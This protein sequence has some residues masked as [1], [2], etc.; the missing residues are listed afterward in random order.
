MNGPTRIEELLAARAL[1]GL[2]EAE[3]QELERLGAAGDDSYD[4]AAAAV[5]LAELNANPLPHELAA[6]VL[7][8]AP[9]P[10]AT[11]PQARPLFR[12]WVVGGWA[13]AAA[14]LAIAAAAWLR[15]P[16]TQVV[17]RVIEV[18]QRPAPP[19]RGP[20]PAEARAALLTEADDVVRLP[21]KPTADADALGASGDVVWSESR[22]VGYMRIRGL[23]SNDPSLAQYQLWIFD[24]KRD[25]RHPVDGGVFDVSGDEVVIP[26]RAKLQV[27]LPTLFA[28]TVEK[29]G[30]AVVSKRE[31]IVLT[32]ASG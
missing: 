13:T 28:V 32:A 11:D 18:P 4:W 23:A 9:R 12:F 15:P 7:A 19:P 21:W 17:E 5:A 16:A 25:A 2:T 22:Q 20:T 30:G 26:I 29:P 3:A 31:R 8:A 6:R 10:R 24:G 27:F 14:C 1:E